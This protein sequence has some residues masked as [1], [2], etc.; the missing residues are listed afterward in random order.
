MK[1]DE[2]DPWEM[3]FS[4]AMPYQ[5]EIVR[6]LLFENDIV[7]VIINKQDSAYLTFGEIELYVKR[8]EILKAKQ[9]TNILPESE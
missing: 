4:S 8:S 6:S 1:D 7:S 9:I 3:I 5:V 2:E